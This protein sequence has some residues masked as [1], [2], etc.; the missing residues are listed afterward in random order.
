[1]AVED[2][3]S[4]TISNLGSG[5][6]NIG[7]MLIVTLVAV[8]IIIGLLIMYKQIKKYKEF[9]VEIFSED[10]FGQT[11]KEY[12]S[13]GIFV[14]KTTRNKRLFLKRNNVGLNADDVP[15][16]SDSKGKKTVYLQKNGL[17]N[18]KFIE[19][20]LTANKNI[21]AEVGEEDVNWA[22][23]AYERAKKAFTQTILMQY[24]PFIVL[25]FV[26]IVILIMFLYFFQQFSVLKELGVALKEASQ[27]LGSGTVVLPA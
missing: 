21:K 26:S 25:A 24:L 27:S 14:D 10:T 22:V 6:L 3:I 4:G 8:G 1:M 11:K 23:N 20:K 17:K 19:I 12:D 7:L 9:K 18:F 15:Y 13:A 16:V 2:G 5:A